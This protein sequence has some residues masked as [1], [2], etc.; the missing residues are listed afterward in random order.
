MAINTDRIDAVAEKLTC[1]TE[2]MHL[3]NGVINSD[4]S[5]CNLWLDLYFPL[6][7]EGIQIYGCENERTQQLTDL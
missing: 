3:F 7:M 2:K 5:V 1:I 4:T 6:V